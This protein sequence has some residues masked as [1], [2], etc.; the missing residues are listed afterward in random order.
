MPLTVPN[1]QTAYHSGTV[2]GSGITAS[3]SGT[4]TTS[5]TTTTYVPYSVD[6][7]DYLA[8]YWVKRKKGGLGITVRDLTSE[9]SRE[10]GT[11]SGVVIT[12]VVKGTSAF[13]QDIVPG[14]VITEVDGE[15]TTDYQHLTTQ[16]RGKEGR[17]VTFVINRH[18]TLLTKILYYEPRE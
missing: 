12:V 6:R 11:N 3:Y 16:L 18:G 9:V 2:I 7:Y 8:T 14:D 17:N 1:I 13:K 5:G 10:L 4:S 15:R